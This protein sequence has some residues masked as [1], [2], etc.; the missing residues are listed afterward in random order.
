M[1]AYELGKALAEA[2]FSVCNGGYLGTMEAAS[3]GARDGGGEAIGITV[4]DLTY[5]P[6][7][8]YLTEDIVKPDIYSRI[9]TMIDKANAFIVLKGGTGT[10]LELSIIWEN[11][12]KSFSDEKPVIIA[13][14]FWEPLL[15]MMINEK[16]LGEFYNKEGAIKPCTGYLNKIYEVDKIVDFLRNKLKT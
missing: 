6:H 3:K 7:N 1:F 14:S 16:S 12:N 5:Q 10:L 11:I 15:G 8:S 4:T 9:D 2:G 13:S